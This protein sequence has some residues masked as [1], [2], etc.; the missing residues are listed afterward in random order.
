MS[1]REAFYQSF[2][3]L[4]TSSNGRIK[5][6]LLFILTLINAVTHSS[7][8]KGIKHDVASTHATDQLSD[9]T[10]DATNGATFFNS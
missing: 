10:S 8:A 4:N 6:Q 7:M 5:M 1:H 2:T 9:A 3:F